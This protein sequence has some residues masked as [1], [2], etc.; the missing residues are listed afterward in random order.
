MHRVA[1][2][3]VSLVSAIALSNPQ[4][5]NAEPQ[6]GH[7]R[8]RGGS[9]VTSAP[10]RSARPAQ[11]R[12]S[13]RGTSR[14]SPAGS[15]RRIG[16]SKSGQS[17]GQRQTGRVG[18]GGQRQ[19][20]RVGSGGQRQ[21][22]RSGAVASARQGESGAVASA[23][24]GES[25]AVASARQGES[26]GRGQGESGAVA[27][28]RQGESGAVA[29]ARQGESGAV[30]SARQ[31][32]S[33]AVAWSP[34]RKKLE[35]P[36]LEPIL[37]AAVSRKCVRPVQPQR[38]RLDAVA[39]SVKW[40]V[41]GAEARPRRRWRVLSRRWGASPAAVASSQCGNRA[42]PQRHPRSLTGGARSPTAVVSCEGR[43]APVA[44]AVESATQTEELP[45]RRDAHPATA[46]SWD[47][48]SRGTADHSWHHPTMAAEAARG[49]SGRVVTM[50]RGPTTTAAT[51]AVIKGDTAAGT[52]TAMCIDRASTI[53]RSMGRSSTS[54]A[55]R[56]A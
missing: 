43:A 40:D 17:G 15:P 53:R 2:L 51:G 19:T 12:G 52:S 22:G 37:V 28:A 23:R 16:S 5:V 42:H 8:S 54:L 14:R 56:S 44:L 11:A 35:A 39:L 20:G 34:R 50:G 13:S 21:T 36:R 27:S 6:R 18:S 3:T 30:A 55:T 32:E 29:S 38:R 24:Q 41:F 33:G 45:V 48:R 25:G 31:G 26:G 47:A 4:F 49:G 1:V 9:S 7:A 46:A 10:V